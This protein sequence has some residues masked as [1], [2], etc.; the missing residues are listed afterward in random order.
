ME[1]DDFLEHHGIKGMRWGVRRT[2]QQLHPS[3]RAAYLQ[4]KDAKWL[5]KVNTNP[6][7]G[8]ISAKAARESKKLTKQLKQ[9]YKDRGIN[10]KKDALHRSRYDA[11]LKNILEQSLDKAA[12]KV[13]KYPP[14]RLTE[15]H[16]HRHPDGTITALV[17][18]RHN[19]KIVKQQG[20][21]AKADQRRV[22]AETK[23][24]VKAQKEADKAALQ[25]A[26]MSMDQPDDF[27]GLQF[28][29][30]LDSE[31]FVDDV[32]VP[33]GMMHSD[34]DWENFLEHHGI[35]GM[36]WGVRRNPGSD[37]LVGKE[38]S[39]RTKGGLDGNTNTSADHERYTTAM[40]KAKSRG[41][42]SLSN[43]ELKLVANR[44]KNENDFAKVTKE[45]ALANRSVGRK[46][47]DLLLKQAQDAATKA[48]AEQG[49][50]LVEEM[51]KGSSGKTSFKLPSK[52]GGST[53]K[54]TK[55]MPFKV[56]PAKVKVT[57]T[58]LSTLPDL[59]RQQ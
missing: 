8:K 54:K 42:S 40:A 24:A 43:E 31:G 25:H 38:P 59:L 10:I 4:Q 47:V 18:T 16:I 35:K 44:I 58:P 23:A 56:N 46:M 6:K 13:H 15:V 32:Q 20:K 21:I 39:T 22:N 49:K 51:L 52:K 5:A 17:A 12:Y 41:L 28:L 14:S 3:E 26:D 55:P 50:K 19:A 37:G 48:A 2:L 36:R 7:L 11:E 29:L 45:R 30:T 53:P 57:A 33:E 27:D 9:D 34:E 1:L